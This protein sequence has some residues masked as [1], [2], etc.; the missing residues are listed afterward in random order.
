MKNIAVLVYELT[1]EYNCTVLDGIVDFF[2]NKDDV[3]LII[4]PVNIPLSNSSEFDYQ[5]WSSV[6]VLNSESI[7]AFIVITNSF[8]SNISIDT[9]SEKLKKLC[10]KPIVSIS[11]PLTTGV[12]I[13]ICCSCFITDSVATSVFSSSPFS[14]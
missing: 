5:Y 13:S 3:N 7:D 11:V 12:S 6:K 9:L 1:I 8:L 4:S 14:S 2:E 10:S